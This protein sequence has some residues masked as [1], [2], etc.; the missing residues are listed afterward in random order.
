MEKRNNIIFILVILLI[1]NIST[2]YSSWYDWSR[3]EHEG[4]SFK[5]P[6]G[7]KVSSKFEADWGD[8]Y[9]VEDWGYNDPGT[10]ISVHTEYKDIYE[11]YYFITQPT[12]INPPDHPIVH[13][14]KEIAKINDSAIIYTDGVDSTIGELKMENGTTI[15]ISVTHSHFEGNYTEY[16]MEYH[17]NIIKE[18]FDSVKAE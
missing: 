16:Y 18:M 6:E 3:Y 7:Y 14:I 9:L 8:D 10:K 15:L 2:V 5:I 4:Y 1:I 12:P 17:A 13:N 11:Y